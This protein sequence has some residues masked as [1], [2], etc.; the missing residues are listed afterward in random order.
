MT[1]AAH[2]SPSTTVL[3][4]PSPK[5]QIQLYSSSML[6][7]T[8]FVPSLVE[9]YPTQHDMG[10]FCST[11]HRWVQFGPHQEKAVHLH[12]QFLQENHK[13]VGRAP[14]NRRKIGKS[15][16]YN[17]L[18]ALLLSNAPWEHRSAVILLQ[19]RKR[20]NFKVYHL[21]LQQL[22]PHFTSKIATQCTS[23]SSRQIKG[24]N[25]PE[26]GRR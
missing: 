7:R 17:T 8:A 21:L 4:F 25:H 11:G 24:N 10:R 18:P 20:R 6:Q 2:A 22:V 3:L 13:R 9:A 15:N 26:F 14:A 19:G 23:V 16:L 12:G 1:W 5:H